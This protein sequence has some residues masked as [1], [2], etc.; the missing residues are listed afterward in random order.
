MYHHMLLT[1]FYIMSYTN[2][3]IVRI[4]YELHLKIQILILIRLCWFMMFNTIFNNILVISWQS[5]L[6]V[7]ETGVPRKTHRPV[8]NHWQTLSRSTVSFNYTSPWTGF[9][10]APLVVIDTDCIGSCKSN[11]QLTFDHDH[12]DPF[13]SSNG[14]MNIKLDFYS[15]SSLKQQPKGS[16]IYLIFL[17]GEH[18]PKFTQQVSLEY[19]RWLTEHFIIA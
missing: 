13:Y 4:K 1:M 7:E 2:I 11:Y 19:Q 15:A 12:D 5:V 18:S 10:L 16:R 17:I 8:A 6:F 14:M 9:E 3:D